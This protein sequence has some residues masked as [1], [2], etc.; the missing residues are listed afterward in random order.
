MFWDQYG[1]Q[2]LA[3]AQMVWNGI[4][5]AI[6]GVLKIILGLVKVFSSLFTGDWNGLWKG[7]KQILEGAWGLIKGA[8]QLAFAGVITLA[9]TKIKELGE[10]LSGIKS[11][12]SG[13]LSGV[14]DAI[15]QPF[16]DMLSGIVA[17]IRNAL[18]EISPF[19]RHSPSL[20]DEV[21]S[22]VRI[23]QQEYG[24]L[25]DISMGSPRLA[26]TGGSTTIINQFATGAISIPIG[27]VSSDYDIEDIGEKLVDYLARKGVR[28]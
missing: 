6:D 7:V 2:I 9:Q 21:V 26:G 12:I 28:L 23:I 18:R 4:K 16:R 24:K 27:N 8:F 22:G 13:W 25:G 3:A 14:A 5:T 11:S 1:K 19:T 15:A 20:V 17:K 10:K